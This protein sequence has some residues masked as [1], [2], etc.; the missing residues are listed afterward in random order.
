MTCSVLARAR[1]SIC[2]CHRHLS[3]LNRVRRKQEI[4]DVDQL[5]AGPTQQREMDGPAGSIIA[6]I[7]QD[8]WAA[9]YETGLYQP[10]TTHGEI[11]SEV[12]FDLV[13]PA[14]MQ[15][16]DQIELDLVRQHVAHRVEV[17]SIEAIDIN[18]Q[19][20]ALLCGQHR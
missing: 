9:I 17:A 18:G 8:R 20:G 19:P 16:R 12:I 14:V 6:E 10:P 2:F 11:L 7:E 15:L 4:A 13:A 5:T 1:A 3:P